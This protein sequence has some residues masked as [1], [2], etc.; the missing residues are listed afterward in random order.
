MVA[1]DGTGLVVMGR[2]KYTRGRCMRAQ[3]CVRLLS[4]YNGRRHS[5]LVRLAVTGSE[6]GSATRLHGEVAGGP[7]GQRLGE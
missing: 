3:Y 2:P 6:L 7:G 1:E 5:L 4:V